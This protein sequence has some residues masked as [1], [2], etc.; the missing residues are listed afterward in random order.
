MQQVR[1]NIKSFYKGLTF[2]DKLHK[3]YVDGKP[4]DISVSGKIKK[5]KPEFN[6]YEKAKEM[7][8]NYGRPFQEYLDEWKQKADIACERGNQAHL[9]G[10]MYAF[11]RSIRP[12]TE[13]DI[14]IM[15]FWQ[16]L[17]P[18]IVPAFVEL[19]MFHKKYLY[20]GTSDI[21]LYN[22][23][24]GKYIIADYKTNQDLFKNFKGQT[25]LGPFSHLLDQPYNH[26]QI[27]LSYYQILFEQLGLEVSHRKIVWL[28][29]V[30]NKGTYK[31]YDTEDFT[32]ILKKEEL[33]KIEKYAS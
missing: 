32:D 27:Q 29:D 28:Q 7:E 24:S 11:D 1:E 31:V 20:A 17:P 16:D 9:F 18:H 4:L 26:Y 15:K 12:R 10:E 30:N 2:N 5:F 25:M 19:Q 3:Y 21:L 22:I 6:S 33:N 23:L 8:A 13:L 14:A